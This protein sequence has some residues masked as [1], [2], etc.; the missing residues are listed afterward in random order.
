MT[1]GV[2]GRYASALFDL[3]QQ[4]K[5]VPAVASALEA[6]DKAIS[7]S[8]DFSRLL[9]SPTFKSEDQMEALGA[10]ANRLGVDGIALNFLKLMCDNRRLSALPDAIKAFQAL[11]SASKGE[12]IA[13]VTSAEELSAAQVKDLKAALKE[14]MGQDVQLLTKTDSSL[15]GGL[16]VKI[17]SMMIDNSLKTKLANLKVAMKGTG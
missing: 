11:V 14:R 3:A 12:A 1:S 17:G 6:L 5:K 13:E 8:S 10:L 7:D 16:V 2:A 4:D 9:S 15:L